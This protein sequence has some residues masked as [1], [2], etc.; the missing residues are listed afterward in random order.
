M[1]AA[2]NPQGIFQQLSGV[3]HLGKAGGAGVGLLGADDFL[4]VLYVF[5]QVGEFL[6][7][8][9]L[10]AIEMFGKLAKEIEQVFALGIGGDEC[11]EVGP[12]ILHQRDCFG[13]M[14][15]SGFSQPFG[16]EG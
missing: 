13:Q 1:A 14:D 16:D 5:L 10:F 8:G 3:D 15:D 12:M 4:D 9:R 7:D 2:I 11:S 6:D